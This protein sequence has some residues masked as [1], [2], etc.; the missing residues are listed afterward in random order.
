MRQNTGD[1]YVK[2]HKETTDKLKSVRLVQIFVLS[3]RH[4]RILASPPRLRWMCCELQRMNNQN[5]RHSSKGKS[6]SLSTYA[7]SKSDAQTNARMLHGILVFYVI[8][9]NFNHLKIHVQNLVCPKCAQNPV[10]H[11]KMDTEKASWKSPRSLRNH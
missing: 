4:P 7:S 11:P 1:E 5:I 6:T 3:R 9:T 8:T 2:R 10:F